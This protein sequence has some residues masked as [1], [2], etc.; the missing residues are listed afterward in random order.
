MDNHVIRVILEGVDRNFSPMLAAARKNV[1]EFTRYLKNQNNEIRK[2]QLMGGGTG[3]RIDNKFVQDIRQTSTLMGRIGIEMREAINSWKNG[4]TAARK[5]AEDMQRALDRVKEVRGEAESAFERKWD[6]ER[7]ERVAA[8]EKTLAD[9]EKENQARLKS[10]EEWAQEQR[11]AIDVNNDAD[12]R[13]RLE[14][15][16][17]ETA[18]RKRALEK[19]RLDRYEANQTLIA[20]QEKD[21]KEAQRS[22]SGVGASTIGR[23]KRELKE[24]RDADAEDRRISKAA[25]EEEMA[26]RER[27]AQAIR[28]EDR[29]AIEEEIR[30]METSTRAANRTAELEQKRQ[31][32]ADLVHFERMRTQARRDSREQF[33]LEA[34]N[35]VRREQQ[36]ATARRRAALDPADRRVDVLSGIFRDVGRGARASILDLDGWSKAARKGET[37]A[38]RFGFA[39]TEMGSNLGEVINIR[40]AAMLGLLTTFATLVTQGAIALTAMA[41]SAVQAGAALGGAFVAGLGQAIPILGAFM[42]GLR[43]FEEVR[44]VVELRK[45]ARDAKTDNAEEQERAQTTASDNLKDAQYSL[46]QA[47]E[48]VGDAQNRVRDAHERVTDALREQRE[49]AQGLAEARREA[50]RN[51]I[52]AALDE[53]DA[54]LSV[55]EAELDLL[56]ARRR[57]RADGEKDRRGAADLEQARAEVQEA[58]ARLAAAQARGDQEGISRGTSALA[59]AQNNLQGIQNEIDEQGDDPARRRIAYERAQINV[60]QA[61]IRAQEA[62]EENRRRQRQ[63]V[64]GSPEVQAARERIGAAERG[65]RDARRDVISATR[66]VRDAEHNLSV[67]SRNVTRAREGVALATADQAAQAEKAKREYDKLSD[68]EKRQV[69]LLETLVKRWETIGK[70]FTDPFTQGMNAIL[71]SV[72]KLIDDPEIQKALTDLMKA[73]GEGMK[74][75]AKFMVDP[76]TREDILFFIKNAADNLPKLVKGLLDVL[77][78]FMRIGVAATPIF[79]NLLDRF[80]VFVGVVEGKTKS[81]SLLDQAIAGIG[82]RINDSRAEQSPLEK[83]L[84]RASKHLDSW[85]HLGTAIGKL[86]L[87]ITGSGAAD[88]GRN[89]VEG[90]ADAF[91]RWGKWINEHPEEVTAFFKKVGEAIREMAPILLAFIQKMVE[92][93]TDPNIQAFVR[94]ILENFLPVLT[95]A[96]KIIGFLARILMFL[97]DIPILGGIL[98]FVFQMVILGGVVTKLFPIFSKLRTAVR[99]AFLVFGV[100]ADWVIGLV[101]K[102]F[103]IFEWLAKGIVRGFKEWINAAERLVRAWIGGLVMVV[104]GIV[105]IF[106]WVWDRIPDGLMSVLNKIVDWFKGLGTRVKNALSGLKDAVTGLG[107][108][109][110]DGMRDGFI[111]MLN[112][113]IGKLNWLIK[114]ANRLPGVDIGKIDELPTGDEMRRRR[115]AEAIPDPGRQRF[116]TGG[117]ALG[118]DTV[119]AMLTPGEWVLN[120]MQQNK[121]ARALQM[122]LND[123][124]MFLFG[125]QGKRPDGTGANKPIG[126]KGTTQKKPVEQYG[127]VKIHPFTDEGGELVNFIE[128][129]DGSWGQ[130]SKRDAKRVAAS[131]GKWVP[132]YVRRNIHNDPNWIKT[133]IWNPYML[134]RVRGATQHFAMGG[135]VQPHVQYFAGGGTVQRPAQ[136][137]PGGRGTLEQNFTI[138]TA[139]PTV[140]V[141]YVMRVAG[142]HITSGY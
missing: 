61:R 30:Q 29:E 84:A 67:S 126:V 25:L 83:F 117:V 131:G 136:A 104:R 128:M 88:E 112:W 41:A 98:K 65:V 58:Q 40:F 46:R 42:A 74:E 14:I 11:E 22:G 115:A 142:I 134:N 66:G 76:E 52:K 106:K 109:L 97:F 92:A 51:I 32:R 124:K 95:D 28:D 2:F 81:F 118:T 102:I 91:D 120:R 89:L 101:H 5:D 93:F 13:Q 107:H 123:A 9:I 127:P 8:N 1:D 49:A 31:H 140:D 33:E 39:I 34:H 111:N 55:K 79:N 62:R 141:D 110:W 87:S 24:K 73:I 18:A 37:A 59:A 119:P 116:A 48:G 94:F 7:A 130:V 68:A 86:F 6:K 27:A 103:D 113:V 90:I 70:D 4:W 135:I 26:M 85:L 17:A 44:K 16:E 99:I 105:K 138:N 57:L 60:R 19:E 15:I 47:I 132:G 56:E 139:S 121:L 45:A 3:S 100:L 72:L 35:Q 50:S 69:A 53:R 114:Q 54:E 20:Q 63:G 10:V 78:I 122:T 80:L 137:G 43:R 23:M 64:E 36:E 77:R 75:F 21:L 96:I 133:K 38:A 82:D 129:A 125:T 71:E 12:K 108:T